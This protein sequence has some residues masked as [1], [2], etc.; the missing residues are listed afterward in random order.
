MRI[1]KLRTIM[2]VA[3]AFSLS[4]PLS[5]SYA[6][7][8]SVQAAEKVKLNVT[9]K[10]LNVGKTLQLTVSGTKEG[11]TWKSDKKSV[12][13]VS[14]K[15]VVKAVKSGK[16][17][18]TASY[19]KKSL[20]CAITVMNPKIASASFKADDYKAGDFN[21]VYPK[22]W[23]KEADVS[24]TMTQAIFYDSKQKMEQ[25]VAVTCAPTGTD[26]IS[27]DSFKELMKEQYTKDT[28]ISTAKLNGA[29]KAT[30]K[31]FK[32]SDYK[33]KLGKCFKAVYTL[34]VEMNGIKEEIKYTMWVVNVDGYVI[35][36][37]ALED[38]S[39]KAS[40]AAKIGEAVLNSITIL[41]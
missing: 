36:V 15:G 25:Q 35:E 21:I 28:I 2:A 20:T 10:T 31:G 16:A 17:T 33:S 6:P 18:I 3:L 24:D 37:D 12:A 7:T 34:K 8:T 41:K 13:T 4:I 32:T 5:Q 39:S 9:K 40:G 27:Y 19:G 1:K 22:G 14:K 23:H 26:A 38:A 30:V 29:D 11:I